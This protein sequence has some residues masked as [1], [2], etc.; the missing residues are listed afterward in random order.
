MWKGWSSQ[1]DLIKLTT[2]NAKK[3]EL[4]ILSEK[5]IQKRINS[6]LL[7]GNLFLGF[8]G[9]MA[10]ETSTVSTTTSSGATATSAIRTP[11]IQAEATRAQ[12]G[13]AQRADAKQATIHQMLLRHETVFPN[14]W[15]E[16]NLFFKHSGRLD[17]ARVTLPIG[18][19]I[20][21]FAFDSS[22][23][24][25]IDAKPA[26]EISSASPSNPSSIPMAATTISDPMQRSPLSET[27]IGDAAF[28][29]L[30]VRGTLGEDL[31]FIV[32]SVKRDSPAARAG[33]QM[34]D[35][36]IAVGGRQIRTPD[37]LNA[38]LTTLNSGRISVDLMREGWYLEAQVTLP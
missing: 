5:E 32:A 2:P 9:G 31:G 34:E 26:P 37:D 36:L 1:P 6:K 17:Q 15:T 4:N 8:L 20:F 30:G 19:R 33:L 16:G 3:P 10:T 27:Q 28:V 23:P 25:F 35:K 22:A 18:G 38:I 29:V 24:S 11:D 21:D 7:F 14:S 13:R 12:R